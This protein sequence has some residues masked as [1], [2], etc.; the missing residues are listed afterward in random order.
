MIAGLDEVG[1]GC[2]AGAVVAAAVILDPE[3]PVEGL[4]DS[5]KLTASKR[6][7]LAQEIKSK[8]LCWAIG[9]AEASEIDQINI[10][11]ASLLAM[12]R[13]YSTLAIRPDWVQVDGKQYPDIDCPGETII[14]GD[15]KEAVISAASILAKVYRDNEMAVLDQLYPEYLFTKHK[16][17]PTKLHLEVIQQQGVTDL[18]RRS[19][20]PVKK[21]LATG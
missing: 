12:A 14:Q 17:Y 19:Y 5:K 8:A 2:I 16:A 6:V 10:L 11:Q 20:A 15:A 21:V 4:M 13:A 1:R 9:R 18:H 3:R 7:K